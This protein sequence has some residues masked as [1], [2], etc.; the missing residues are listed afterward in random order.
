MAEPVLFTIGDIAV[1]EHWIMTPRGTVP[2]AEQL[3]HASIT[4]TMDTYSHVMP[5]MKSEAAEKVAGL[6]L[7][8]GA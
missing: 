8:G 2:L 1:T 3:G 6:I 7:G 5:T 4:I